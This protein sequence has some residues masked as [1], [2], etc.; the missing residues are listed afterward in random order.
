[1]AIFPKEEK[2]SPIPIIPSKSPLSF[3]V[4]NSIHPKVM[5]M[6]MAGNCITTATRGAGII[7]GMVGSHTAAHIGVVVTT[8]VK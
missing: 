3:R 2:L 4:W 8:T 5:R 6:D 7:G 1:M